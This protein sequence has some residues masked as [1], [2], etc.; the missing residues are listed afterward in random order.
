[1]VLALAVVLALQ[2]APPPGEP[3][4]EPAAGGAA[5]AIAVRSDHRVGPEDVLSVTV[6]GHADLV[7]TVVVDPAG[8]FVF[9]LVGRV[10][11]LGL[12]ARET[13]TEL[14]RRLADGFIRAPIVSV[15][16]QRARSSSVYVIGEVTRPGV[17]TLADAH[18]LLE[19]L[20]L[21]GP[22]LGGAG[23]EVVILRAGGAGHPAS[24]N[25]PAPDV[26]RVRLKDLQAGA[27]GENVELQASDTVLVPRATQVVVTGAVKHP[28]AYPTTPETTVRQVIGLAGGFSGRGTPARVRIVR[29]DGA[30]TRQVIAGVDDLVRPDD[31]VVVE[32]GL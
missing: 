1:M 31:T 18:T 24:A 9:P 23:A 19:L 27:S 30:G 26:V 25:S 8:T 12:T 10:K 17:Y 32:K 6:F 21:A 16:V 5:R 29:Q 11:A 4:T 22:M 28:G 3:A 13:E 7:H 14:A 20:A 2:G 15:V